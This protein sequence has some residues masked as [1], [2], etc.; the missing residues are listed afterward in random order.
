[1][2]RGAAGSGAW[3]DPWGLVPSWSKS[4]SGGAKM[5]NAR[6]ETVHEKP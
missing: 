5:I 3:A 4:L 1:M 2:R 6:V